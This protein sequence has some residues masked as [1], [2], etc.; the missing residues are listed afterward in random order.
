MTVGV[1]LNASGAETQVDACVRLAEEAAAAGLRSAWF[2]QTLGA[3]SPQLAAV[4]GCEAPGLHVGTSA[5]PVFGR[6]PLLVSSQAQTAQG[7]T[8]GR[9]HLGLA[10]GTKL[11]TEGGFGPPFER[12]VARLREFLIALSQLT[13]TGTADFHGELLTLSGGRRASDVAVIGDEKAVT[14]EVRRHRDAG[15][16]EVVF[17]GS[18]FAGEANRKRTWALLGELAG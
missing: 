10:L 14:D 2:G 18:E 4:V 6:H 16:T 17:S 3:D 1:A 12:P 5:I 9:Y 8:H 13:Q 11:L 7:A 15:A